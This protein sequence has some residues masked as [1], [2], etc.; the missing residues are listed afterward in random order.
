M[1]ILIQPVQLLRFS[2]SMQIFMKANWQLWDSLKDIC[3]MFR[4]KLFLLLF[5]LTWHKQNL[6]FVVSRKVHLGIGS[7]NIGQIFLRKFPQ[8]NLFQYIFRFFSICF[9]TGIF[10]FF[11]KMSSFW[12]SLAVICYTYFFFIYFSITLI[13]RQLIQSLKD[14][15]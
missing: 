13:I 15:F 9:S 2:C 8:E 4:Q 6:H 1:Q 11:K 3:I 10:F 5:H 12:L 7:S 14:M